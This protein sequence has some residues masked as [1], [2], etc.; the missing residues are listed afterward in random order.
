MLRL[1]SKANAEKFPVCTI[2]STPDKPVHC[3]VWAKELF[4]YLFGDMSAS[5]LNEGPAAPG[6]EGDDGEEDD[7]ES[8]Y[9]AICARALGH[10]RRKDSKSWKPMRTM[11]CMHFSA[12]RFKRRSPSS[13]HTREQSTHLA[14]IFDFGSEDSTITD[15]AEE[16][17][18]S[19]GGHDL[20]RGAVRGHHAAMHCE[21]VDGPR[22][23]AHRGSFCGKV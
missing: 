3:I 8:V 7:A 20:D 18:L 9:M 10:K 2:R 1:R 17:G 13:Q 12:S 11:F 14:P 22:P 15:I 5:M 16:G 19:R 21:N 6:N 23:P 4:K